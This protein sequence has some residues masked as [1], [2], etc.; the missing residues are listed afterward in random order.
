MN[1]NI[2]TVSTVKDYIEQN[3]IKNVTPEDAA[4]F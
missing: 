1:K 3:I 2:E 4:T